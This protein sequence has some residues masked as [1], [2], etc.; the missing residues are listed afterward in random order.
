M[1]HPDFKFEDAPN[2]AAFCCRHVVEGD[3]ILYVSHDRDGDWQFLCGCD[4]H[5]S[6]DCVVLC[7]GDVVKR[8]ASLNALAKMCGGHFAER[9]SSTAPW[10]ITDETE[11]FIVE[12]IADPGWSV[13]MIAAGEGPDEPAFGYTIGLFHNY[14]QPELIVVGLRHELMHSM[15]NDVAQRIKDGKVLAVG[16]KLVDVLEGFDVTLREVRTKE[17]FKQH[18][19]YAL[20]FYKGKPFPLFQL[21]WPDKQGRFPKEKGT[22]DG[23]NAQQPLL[24]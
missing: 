15:L 5:A 23:F 21:V 11:R 20:W 18:V 12:C 14:Q 24:P 4:E 13:Q 8:D 16:E 7:L 1:P 2:T 17:S 3:P 19:G 10:S 9:P 22:S 6:A